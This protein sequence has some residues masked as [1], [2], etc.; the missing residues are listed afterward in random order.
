MLPLFSISFGLVGYLQPLSLLVH[1]KPK[2]IR[3]W[4]KKVVAEEDPPVPLKAILDAY[5]VR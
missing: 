1:I 4:S 5:S 2:Y 3:L